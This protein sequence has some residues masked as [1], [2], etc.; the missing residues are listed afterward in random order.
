MLLLLPEFSMQMAMPKMSS[1][2]QRWPPTVFVAVTVT[3]L[4]LTVVVT[5]S[6]GDAVDLADLVGVV[7]VRVAVEVALCDEVAL[8]DEE[9]LCVEEV[10]CDEEVLCVEEALCDEEVLCVDE[11]LVDSSQSS[12]LELGLGCAELV[13]WCAWLAVGVAVT[14][15]VT[16]CGEGHEPPLLRST[17]SLPKGNGVAEAPATTRARMAANL[18]NCIVL[19]GWSLY[20]KRS[21][22][23]CIS[24]RVPLEPVDLRAHWPNKAIVAQHFLGTASVCYYLGKQRVGLQMYTNKTV[25][26]CY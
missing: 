5:T 12:D 20:S 10:L 14:V 1:L 8:G 21:V 19:R 6:E 11:A 9:V 22:I 25:A 2:P 16:V 17:S 26:Q 18:A 4:P 3:G 7:D 13:A 23:I 15:T 24:G